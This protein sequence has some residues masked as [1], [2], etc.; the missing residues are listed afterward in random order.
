MSNTQSK[1]EKGNASVAVTTEASNVKN[2]AINQGFNVNNS[3]VVPAN[4]QPVFNFGDNQVRVVVR[5]GAPW[6]VAADI[7]SA[8]K[9]TNPSKAMKVLEPHERSNFKLGRQGDVNIVSESGLYTLILRCRDAIKPG[10]VAHQFKTW[11][12]SEVLP[13]IRKTG[14]YE[15]QEFAVNPGDLLTRDEA[16]TLRLMLKTAADRLPKAKQGALMVQ[17]WS[18]LKSHFGVPYREIPRHEFSEAVSIIARHTAEWHLVDEQPVPR[19]SLDDAV[20]L[21]HA[22]AMATQAAAKVQQSVFNGVI[23][24]NQ[25]WKRGRFMLSFGY[26]DDSANAHVKQIEEGAYVATLPQ[27]AKWIQDPGM[28]IESQELMGLA[29]ACMSRLAQ[30]ISVPRQAAL[31]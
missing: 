24:G 1:P 6:F 3:T 13:S 26:G 16:E 12:T 4:S 25:D 9:L 15:R 27:M 23:A 10:T 5:E 30:R 11:V 31:A 22:F 20:L 19:M 18:K 29:T 8:L 28:L 2:Q 21:D 14:G 17:G 7:W